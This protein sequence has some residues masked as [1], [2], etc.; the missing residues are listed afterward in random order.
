MMIIYVFTGLAINLKIGGILEIFCILHSL[1][2]L[3][4]IQSMTILLKDTR[5]ETLW[6]IGYPLKLPMMLGTVLLGT[7]LYV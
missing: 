1:S 7:G 2:I 6:N 3:I 5:Q 4:L